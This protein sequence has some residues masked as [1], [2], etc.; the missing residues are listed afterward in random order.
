MHL[1]QTSERCSKLLLDNYHSTTK[2]DYGRY[3]GP[4][5]SDPLPDT[6]QP[7]LGGFTQNQPKTLPTARQVR[8]EIGVNWIKMNIID[9]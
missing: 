5:G 4:R 9:D 2:R 8:L 7:F 3:R 1:L 6:V